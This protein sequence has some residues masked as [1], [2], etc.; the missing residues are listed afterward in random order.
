MELL[1]ALKNIE[2]LSQVP[3]EQLSWLIDRS[4]CVELAVGQTMFAPGDPIDRLFIVLEGDFNLKV[5]RNNQFQEIGKIGTGAISGML[6]YSRAQT[7]RAYAEAVNPAKMIAL[8]ASHFKEM[9]CDC[10]ELTTV[11]VHAMSTRI[12]QFTKQEQQNDK[13]MALGK[14]SAGLAH[15]LNNPSAAV[16]RSSQELS[17]HL[18]FLPEK[19][20]SVIKI[21]MTDDQVDQVNDVLFSKVEEGIK[22]LSLIEKSELEDELMDWLDDRNVEDSDEIA[23]NFV[24]YGLTV[25]DL[26]L[27][28]EVTPDEHQP[29][30]I[31]WL[32]QV[33]TTE[34][35]VNEIE[36]A[37]Q[38]IND[39]VTS[40]KSYTHMDQAPEKM[41]TDVH[42]GIN[43]TLTMLN[44][45][46][47]NIEV[48]KE[49]DPDLPHPSILPSQ[50][51]QVWT[52]ILDNAID[53]MEASDTKRLS[54][55]TKRD[56]E[57]VNISIQDSGSGIPEEIQDKVFD[58]F[59]TTKAIGKGTG[60]GLE[61]VQQ[62]IKT[63]HNG[64]IYLDSK[65][66]KTIF[67]ICIPIK[68]T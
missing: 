63:Q 2:D 21:K 32:N 1:T 61:F 64:A 38:R 67:T 9:I 45:K 51:N 33:M 68:A 28:A 18:K 54:I 31:G 44:H 49:Y 59:Y 7:A 65:P 58:P 53:A 35:L 11:F 14:L 57:F 30:V 3:E 60:L 48:V 20:K 4:E 15:E 10:H 37:S 36:D 24:D 26:D 17:K 43:N 29:P 39:L 62:I 23:A 16:V 47:K 12:R 5:E 25:D 66:G 19:F 55:S 46:L 40:V 56:G 8:N 22:E 42:V 41:E 6:P 13:M 50:I 52:N 27:I 34:R